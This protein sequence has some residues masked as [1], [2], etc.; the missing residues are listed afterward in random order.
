[1]S[2]LEQQVIE[3]HS[4]GM[5]DTEIGK[6]INR[7]SDQ[8]AYYRKKNNLPNNRMNKLK[9][10]K[11]NILNDLNN[12]ITVYKISRKYKISENYIRRLA[13]ENL[14]PILKFEEMVNNRRVVKNNPFKNL[15]SKDTQYWL[16]F[17]CADGGLF[18][19]RITL[20]L[21]EKD[22]NHIDKYI[23]FIGSKITKKLIKK[24][25]NN[26]IFITYSTSFRSTIVYNF[27]SSLGIIENKSLILEYKG[28]IT[29]DFLRGVID[30]D[31]YIRKNHQE[32][33]IS[34]GSLKFAKQLQKFIMSYYKVNCTIRLAKIN[35]YCV[36]VYGG[37]QVGKILNELYQNANTYLERKYFNA[38]LIRNN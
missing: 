22:K 9:I 11:D 34:T 3:L 15:D 21:Q 4:K 18:G 23:N 33:S 29:N 8:V 7:S 35:L 28:N 5:L 10:N 14:I 13:K 38:M 24:I 37:K 6:I 31:G 30:G 27:L 36:G 26:K 16:G 2:K 25:M 32:V 1:M 17:L 19:N 12:K 20:G